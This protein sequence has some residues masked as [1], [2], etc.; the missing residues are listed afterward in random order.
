M[1]SKLN[2]F[3]RNKLPEFKSTFNTDQS[4]AWF[5]ENLNGKSMK[6]NKFRHVNYLVSVTMAFSILFSCS[7]NLDRLPTN[8]ISNNS[9][10][11]TMDGYKESLVTL[12]STLSE[13]YFLRE[14]WNM[15]EIPTDEAVMTWDDPQGTYAYNQ[16]DWTSD[17]SAISSVYTR[18]MYN[19]TLC[20]NFIIESEPGIVVQ[21][22]YSGEDAATISTYYAE[23]RFLRAYFYWMMLDLFGNPPF[24]TE[25]TL[26]G[27]N[28][29]E[30]INQSNLFAYIA[31][32]LQ[33]IEIVLLPPKTNE[34]GRA[35]QAAAWSLLARLYLNAEIGRAH[36]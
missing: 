31:S 7:D 10:Y 32:E 6:Q 15:Q 17:N 4:Q 1:M 14:Y 34:Y 21:R 35:D 9:L 29:P 2:I 36:V 13:G 30:Q 28:P 25:E 33:D 26:I 27:G 23:A 5:S 22:G 24:A 11:S 8:G 12:Y 3:Q 19:I 16:M 18:L 20:N